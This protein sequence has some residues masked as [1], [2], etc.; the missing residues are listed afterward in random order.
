MKSLNRNLTVASVALWAL[1]GAV[2]SATAVS[3]NPSA[4]WLGYMNVSEIPQNGGAYVFGSGWGTADLVATW[5]GPTLTLAPNSIGDPNFFWYTPSGGPGSVGNKIMDAS[6]Y[7]EI[8]SL[9]G[10]TLSFEGNVLAN[11]LVGKTDANGN[12]WTS[13]AFIKDFASDYSSYN[14]VTAPLVNG[15]FSISLLTV[16]DPARHVQYGFET[17][18]PDVWVTDLAPYGSIQ[19][20]PEP[21]SLALIG[22]GALGLLGLRRRQ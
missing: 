3:V 2:N 19:V 5:S 4:T 9:P 22:L 21:S 20:V 1:F 15:L 14:T 7:V 10:Q 6:M 11:T 16:N 18:G 17:I 13:V 12:G 8:G